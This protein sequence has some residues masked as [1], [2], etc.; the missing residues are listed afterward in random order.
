[1]NR[2]H[3]R[4]QHSRREETDREERECPIRGHLPLPPPVRESR[5]GAPGETRTRRIQR[6]G[7]RDKE[8]TIPVTLHEKEKWGRMASRAGMSLAA[9]MRQGA[10]IL[11]LYQG[12]GQA[13]PLSMTQE[14]EAFH[15]DQADDLER[16]A[17]QS[18]E[19]AAA[20]AGWRRAANDDEGE[21]SPP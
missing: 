3:N 7:K 12:E 21:G 2:E 5:R 10:N 20:M 8:I 17:A 15:L 9:Y 16:M 13:V 1:M 4:E 11:A 6:E 18:R 19:R 14:A